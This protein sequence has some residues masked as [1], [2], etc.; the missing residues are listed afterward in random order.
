MSERPFHEIRS[1][2]NPDEGVSVSDAPDSYGD[3]WISADFL[4]SSYSVYLRE[5]DDCRQLT[6]FR[7]ILTLIINRVHNPQ[8]TTTEGE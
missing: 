8:T 4:E 2:F 3:V 5:T 1:A 6:Q 7:D